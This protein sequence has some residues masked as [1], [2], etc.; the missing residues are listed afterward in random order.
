MARKK[1]NEAYK[2]E[3][4]KL[5]TLIIN[6]EAYINKRTKI[7]HKHKSCGYSWRVTPDNILQGNGCP[8][9]YLEGRTKNSITYQ[10]ELEENFSD[11]E[12]IEDYINSYTKIL[13][14][15]TKCGHNFYATPNSILRGNSKCRVCRTS[16]GFDISKPAVL[17]Y[18]SVKNGTAFKIGI[19]NRTVAERY[20]NEELL[21]ITLLKE[22][23]FDVGQEAYDM[24]Q[25]IL[26]QYKEFKYKGKKLL[27]SGN[28]E[29]FFL[30]VLDLNKN[31]GN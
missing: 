21:D 18:L 11:F 30:D 23:Y 15:H 16:Y 25:S 27:K 19:T 20:T 22:W 24:E 3:L 17:Y 29:L 8:I 14:K 10:K 5:S 28:T 1:T 6:M 12:V 13:H 7:L 4:E 9:C 2:I 31:K 26:K